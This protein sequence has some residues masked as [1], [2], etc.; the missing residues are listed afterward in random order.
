M[1]IHEKIHA[2]RKQK[3]LTQEDMADKLE[4]SVGGYAKI[5]RGE[6]DYQLALENYLSKLAKIAKALEVDLETLIEST[7]KFVY[8]VGSIDGDNHGFNSPVIGLSNELTFEIQKLQ[9]IIKNKD[10]EIEHKNATIAQ[11]DIL[12]IQKDKEI[13]HLENIIELMKHKSS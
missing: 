1:K 3:K 12:I 9:L 6:T 4:M 7:K 10:S 5:E 13:V 11:R 2:L 8:L